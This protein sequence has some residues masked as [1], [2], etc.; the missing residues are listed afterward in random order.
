M[1]HLEDL[2]VVAKLLPRQAREL[3]L[4]RLDAIRARF[5]SHPQRVI[6]G[7]EEAACARPAEIAN[8][9]GVEIDGNSTR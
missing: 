6:V 4:V 1:R 5:D 2:G 9:T 8:Q 3:V 7:V